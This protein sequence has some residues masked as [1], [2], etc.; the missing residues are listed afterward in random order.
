MVVRKRGGSPLTCS[1]IMVN[2]T[3]VAFSLPEAKQASLQGAIRF[4]VKKR[5]ITR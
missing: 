3:S 1:R 2:A 5:G 4:T